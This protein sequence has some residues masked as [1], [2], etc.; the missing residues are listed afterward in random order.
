MPSYDPQRNRPRQRPS[1]DEP[2]AVDALLDAADVEPAAPS[3]RDD[4]TEE[5]PVVVAPV[6]P[7]APVAAAAAEPAA[8]VHVPDGGHDHDHH[9]H[10][11]DHHDDH[12]DH[13]HDLEDIALVPIVAVAGVLA[14]ALVIVWRWRRRKSG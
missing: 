6:A 1:D 2:T 3:V 12:H 10:D 4:I 8:H 9:G 5:T 13:D 7:V 11:H 14:G